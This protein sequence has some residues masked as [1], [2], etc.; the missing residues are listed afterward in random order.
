MVCHDS[1]YGWQRLMTKSAA[2]FGMGE[3]DVK[4]AKQKTGQDPTVCCIMQP[5]HLF[6][7]F[8]VG[9]MANKCVRPQHNTLAVLRGPLEG[10]LRL[11]R[12]LEP[13]GANWWRLP[14]E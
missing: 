9:R 11:L 13:R 6:R 12:M 1:R 3:I 4:A 8:Y 10:A 5:Y 7:E 2:E 14:A